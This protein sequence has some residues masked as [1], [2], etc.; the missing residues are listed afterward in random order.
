MDGGY[1]GTSTPHI[2]LKTYKESVVLPPRIFNYEPKIHG[3]NLYKKTG[4]RAVGSKDV[5]LFPKF[6]TS[7]IASEELKAI[8]EPRVEREAPSEADASMADKENLEQPPVLDPAPE[9]PQ[10]DVEQEQEHNQNQSNR[11]NKKKNKKNKN[12]GKN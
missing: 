12:R 10:K 5:I 7:S 2:F 6:Y 11:K 1:F 8:H 9:E 4:S 3:F